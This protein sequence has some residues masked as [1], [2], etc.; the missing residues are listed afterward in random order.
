VT[1]APG[2]PQRVLF[3]LQSTQVGGMETHVIDLAGEYVRRGITVRAVV[4]ADPSMDVL[5]PR[6]EANGVEVVRRSSDARRGRLRQ[7]A[8]TPAFIRDIRTFRPDV[9]HL[10][11]GGATGGLGV[12]AMARLAR[13]PVVAVTEHDVPGERPSLHQRLTRGAMDRLLHALI[14]VSRRNAR[15][16]AGR[17]GMPRAKSA[18]ILNGVPVVETSAE[19]RAADRAAVREDFSIGAREVVI[20]SVVR[21]A[22]GKGLEDLLRAFAIVANDAPATR[23]LL[24]GDGPLR[25]ALQALAGELGIAGQAVFAGAQ[26]QPLRFLHA[27]DVFVLAVPAGSMSIALLEAMAAGLPPVI[28]F[29]GPEEAVI[30]AE[31]GLCAPPGDPAGLARVLHTLVADDALRARLA[32]AAAAHVR[33]HFSVA[34]VADDTLAVYAA[35]RTRAPMPHALDA[36]GPPDPRPGERAR[37]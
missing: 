27:M 23:L 22:P 37:R 3:V 34:R 9:L 28:T 1:T 25:E 30:D 29:C 10:Q 21:L 18:A 36:A 5:V 8:A 15:L 16:R 35:A 20:G 13:V 31:T 19:Q 11:T 26:Q 24:V 33:Q 14:A 4:P 2:W 7:L 32:T 12:V 6:F 17:I